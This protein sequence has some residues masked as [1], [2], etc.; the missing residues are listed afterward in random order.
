[1]TRRRRLSKAQ[2]AEVLEQN[3]GCCYL[4]SLPIV[5]PF[6]IEHPVPFALGGSDKIEE[7]RPA[8]IE[9]HAAK[10]KTDVTRIAKAKRVHRK[11]TGQFRPPRAVI[12]G[13]KATR[14]KKK[15]NGAVEMRPRENA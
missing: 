3:G 4:C 12:P 2:R 14:F 6:E 15:L 13:S 8:H 10:T 9:C 5:G 1:M 7:L 11:H